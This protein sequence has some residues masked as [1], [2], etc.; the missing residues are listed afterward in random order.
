MIFC[1]AIQPE[2]NVK[3]KNQD[4]KTPR[5]KEKSNDKFQKKH[6][7]EIINAFCESSQDD[8]CFFGFF[9]LDLLWSL[10]F[11]ASLVLGVLVLGFFVLSASWFLL[12]HN[13]TVP[14]PFYRNNF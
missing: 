1:K 3:R 4:A 14:H 6:Q 9:P 8:W 11:G 10:Y 12:T 5:T 7:K 13:K 2:D